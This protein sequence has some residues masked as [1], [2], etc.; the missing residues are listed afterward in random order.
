MQELLEKAKNGDKEAFTELLTYIEKD[1]Y[2]IARTRLKND[3]DIA[4]VFQ[5]TVIR[6]YKH[7]KKLKNNS[8]FKTWIIKILINNCN[9]L[10]K[11]N[12]SKKEIAFEEMKNEEMLIDTSLDMINEDFNITIKDLSY[13][14]RIALTLY[15]GEGYTSKEIGGI[16]KTN[17]NTIKARILRAKN[18]I[19]KIKMEEKSNG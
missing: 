19:K 10:Y 9:T 13:D 7:I 2:K 6:A 1:L 5:E 15:Y 3:D 4:D 8:Y 14:E 11:K 12:K 18:K 16:L 17:E